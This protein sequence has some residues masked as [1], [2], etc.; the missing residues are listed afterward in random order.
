MKT[1]DMAHD[2]ILFVDPKT[3]QLEL[4]KWF[5]GLK[6][7]LYFARDCFSSDK[8]GYDCIQKGIDRMFLDKIALT[9][10]RTDRQ[11]KSAYFDYSDS[12]MMFKHTVF[13]ADSD[14]LCGFLF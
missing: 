8:S 4:R 5:I 13:S 1:P 2:Q 3:P 14:L 10:R 7:T 9:D 11:T 12:Y 6:R